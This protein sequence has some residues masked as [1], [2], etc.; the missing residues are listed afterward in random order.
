MNSEK[1]FCSNHPN[2]AAIGECARC[3]AGLCGFCAR[4]D[5]TGLY[6][7]A[8]KAVQDSQR[9]VEHESQKLSRPETPV[10]HHER[11]LE[12][13]RDGAAAKSPNYAVHLIIIAVCLCFLAVR[14]YMLYAGARAAPDPALLIQEQQMS[15]LVAC[16]FVFRQIGE[17]LAANLAPAPDLR[18]ADDAG[19]NRIARNGDQV[20][21]SHANPEIYGYQAIY[22]T[23]A[24]IEPVLVP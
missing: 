23:N 14:G 5:D 22:V 12:N 17:Q 6:C 18:C 16:L 9:Y 24:A 21:V 15:S 19:P 10:R 11:S 3:H 4:F 13:G 20:R 7:E 2:A 8:C 1:H